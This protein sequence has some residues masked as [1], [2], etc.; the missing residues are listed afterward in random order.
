MPCT[1]AAR[2][3]GVAA[4]RRDRGSRAQRYLFDVGLHYVG[5]G[6]PGGWFHRLLDPVGVGFERV[7]WNFDAFVNGP[8][9]WG[10]HPDM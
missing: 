9:N 3:I 10:P 1:V 4:A 5:D 6:G 8:G 2:S 7:V